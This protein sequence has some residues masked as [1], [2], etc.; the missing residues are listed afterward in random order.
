[1][2]AEIHHGV[3][4]TALLGVAEEARV[5]FAQSVQVAHLHEAPERE[6]TGRIKFP[7]DTGAEVTKEALG[8]L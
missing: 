6:S 4:I 7:D 8:V 1:M 2:R 3:K 5:A